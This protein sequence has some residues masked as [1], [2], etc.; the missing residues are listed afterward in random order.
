[1]GDVGQVAVVGPVALDVVDVRSF[2]GV[3]VLAAIEDRH[4]VVV[5]AQLGDGMAADEPRPADDERTGVG[6]VHPLDSRGQKHRGDGDR[7]APDRR[8]AED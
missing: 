3:V 5:V 7:S 6:H 8:M 1:V 4:V 2:E